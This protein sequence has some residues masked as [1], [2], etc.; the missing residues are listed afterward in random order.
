MSCKH[1]SLILIFRTHTKETKIMPRWHTLI[2]A[3]G[4][5]RLLA[6]GSQRQES[7][8]GSLAI[9]PRLFIKLEMH[10]IRCGERHH[11]SHISVCTHSHSC[12][13]TT[14]KKTL[15]ILSPLCQNCRVLKTCYLQMP[16]SNT[17]ARSQPGAGWWL[18][19]SA[20]GIPLDAT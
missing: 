12:P 17:V 19:P 13:P 16:T 11:T 4:S 20:K 6:L 8:W 3:L 7:P 15:Q 18:T 9:Q 1:K 10:K 2:L 14:T 5:Q